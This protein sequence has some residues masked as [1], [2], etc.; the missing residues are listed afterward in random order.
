MDTIILIEGELR[1]LIRNALER[2]IG[3]RFQKKNNKN[4]EILKKLSIRV[5]SSLIAIQIFKM[6]KD[7]NMTREYTS[8]IMIAI[9]IMFFVQEY[10]S[11]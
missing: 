2:V 9:F 3:G 4:M 1:S 5:V 8:Y 6:I 11:N 7:N 10:R